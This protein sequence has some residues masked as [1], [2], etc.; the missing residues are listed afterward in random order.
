VFDEKKE[1][2]RKVEEKRACCVYDFGRKYKKK[3]EFEESP[4]SAPSVGINGP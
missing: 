4:L 2:D 1:E 3:C